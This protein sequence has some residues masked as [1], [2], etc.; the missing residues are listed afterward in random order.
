MGWPGMH[1][2]ENLYGCYVVAII[3]RYTDFF[4]LQLFPISESRKLA[5]ASIWLSLTKRLSIFSNGGLVRLVMNKLPL[6]N[7]N[8]LSQWKMYG[9]FFQ[10]ATFAKVTNWSRQ[11]D[12]GCTSSSSVVAVSSMHDKKSIFLSSYD[13]IFPSMRAEKPK[14]LPL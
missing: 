6:L 3:P 11:W 9:C 4:N 1:P 10:F 13:I 8:N 5:K 12:L 7:L 14:I 2:V